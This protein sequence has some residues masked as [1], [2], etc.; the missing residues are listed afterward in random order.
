MIG[1][2]SVAA[3]SGVAPPRLHAARRAS[4]TISTAPKA[5]LAARAVGFAVRFFIKQ[6]SSVCMVVGRRL[7]ARVRKSTILHS[8]C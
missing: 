8:G 2:A 6:S 3:G 1:S 4:I 5:A 7:P